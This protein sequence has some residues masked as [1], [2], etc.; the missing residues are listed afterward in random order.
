MMRPVMIEDGFAANVSVELLQDMLNAKLRGKSSSEISYYLK[1]QKDSFL[2]EAQIATYDELLAYNAPQR[3]GMLLHDDDRLKVLEGKAFWTGRSQKHFFDV[4]AHKPW[5]FFL[6]PPPPPDHPHGGRPRHQRP[7]EIP[8]TLTIQT[9]LLYTQGIMSYKPTPPRRGRHNSYGVIP[10][11]NTPYVIFSRHPAPRPPELSPLSITLNA[12]LIL[13]ILFGTAFGLI[14][15]IIRRIRRI[16]NVCQ[17][18]SNGNYDIRC[19]DK[20]N[21]S[22]GTLA[23]HIDEM[24]ASIERHLG[25][26]KSLLQAVSHELRTPLSRIRFSI[27]MIDIAEDDDKSLARLESIDDDL[28]EIDDL[29]KELGYFNYVDA[30]KGK[31]HF[32]TAAIQ[33]LIDMTLHQRSLALNDFE[34]TTDGIE[35]DMSIEADPTAF[36]RV[37]GNLLGNA[38]RYAKE[39]IQIQVSYSTDKKNIEICVDDDGPGIPEDKRKTIFEPF[40]CLEKSRSKSMTGCGLGLAIADRIMKVHSGSIEARTS[41]L[42]GTRMFTSWPITQSDAK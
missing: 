10:I 1:H 34:V 29:I 33:D 23:A 6:P 9:L 24:T 18:V 5:L 2:N 13:F 42:G 27:E 20:R 14:Y 39:R 37:I 11:S 36:K 22:I 41:P 38:A 17:S 8:H 30:G 26:Q 21:D 12:A 15:P 28:T 19:N 35:E 32:E 3:F 25:Q 40:V 7:P 31:Q 4:P 16:Q